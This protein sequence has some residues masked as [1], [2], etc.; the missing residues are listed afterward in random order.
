MAQQPGDEQLCVTAAERWRHCKYSYVSIPLTP[1]GCTPSIIQV[2]N[3][4]AA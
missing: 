1:S 4:K 2:M 3:E